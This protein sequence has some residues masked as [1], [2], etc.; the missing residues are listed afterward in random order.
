MHYTYYN[1]NAL[2]KLHTY[3][4]PPPP[5]TTPTPAPA[6][7]STTAPATTPPQQQQQQ[8]PQQQQAPSAA[9]AAAVDP[10]ARVE[11]LRASLRMTVYTWVSRGLFERHKLIFLAQVIFFL[12]YTSMV[13]NLV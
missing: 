12:G 5:P 4:V 3:T 8:Q 10:T 9:A 1:T 6:P 7:S 11:Q 2:H 13:L